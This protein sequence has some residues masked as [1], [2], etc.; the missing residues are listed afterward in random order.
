[1]AFLNK[2]ICAVLSLLIWPIACGQTDDGRPAGAGGGM[3]A[4]AGGTHAGGSS[5]PGGDGGFSGLAAG[6]ADGGT[7][8]GGSS[9]IAAGGSAGALHSGGRPS[10]GGNGASSGGG[11]VVEPM[12]GKEGQG[13]PQLCDRLGLESGPL[14]EGVAYGYAVLVYRDCRV[15]A[16]YNALSVAAR[17]TALNELAAFNAELWGC[18]EPPPSDFALT[19]GATTLSRRES[20]LLVSS[21]LDAFSARLL[22]SPSEKE[23]VRK[24]LAA[25]AELSITVEADTLPHSECAS[26]AGGAGGGGGAGGA[27]GASTSDQ[28]SERGG[29]GGRQ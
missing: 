21:Y 7:N 6:A 19:F 20:E 10:A 1:M 18:V 4:G 8:A 9:S 3:H 25:L 16:L 29:A 5:S 28:G 22:P 24:D 15:S 23:K 11:V 12:G 14:S 13:G 27:A 2:P 17:I 26:E